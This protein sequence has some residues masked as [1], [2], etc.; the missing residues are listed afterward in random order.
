MLLHVKRINYL[1]SGA[2][3]NWKLILHPSRSHISLFMPYNVQYFEGFIGNK[4]EAALCFARL[5]EE[6]RKQQFLSIFPP[7]LLMHSN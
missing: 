6:F 3:W 4:K 7:L 1:T 5:K 2:L